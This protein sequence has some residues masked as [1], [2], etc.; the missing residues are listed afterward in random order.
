MTYTYD[1]LA[2]DNVMFLQG[3]QADLNKYLPKSQDAK[4]GTAIEGAFYLT[5]DTHRLYVGR[6][7]NDSNSQD[8][9]KIFPEEV[10]NGISVV[11][12]SGQLP[13]PA[14]V[15]AHDGDLYY[16]KNGNILAAYEEGEGWV[17]INSPTSISAIN[18]TFGSVQTAESGY[19][20]VDFV[21]SPTTSASNPVSLSIGAQTEGGSASDYIWFVPG[22]N[23]SL[24]RDSSDT[25]LRI[26]AI[27]NQELK[28]SATTYTTNSAPIILEEPT[29]NTTTQVNVVGEQDIHV[30]S[31]VSGSTN[32]ITVRGP[33]IQG[34]E[35]APLGTA[36]DS[37][38]VHGFTF[39]VVETS[40]AG[41][42]T[43]VNSNNNKTI[44]PVINYGDT[45]SPNTASS[46]YFHGGTARLDVY[47]ISQTEQAIQDAITESNK[48][49]DALHWKGTING[50]TALGALT[51]VAVG[52]VYK[53]AVDSNTTSTEAQ[54]GFTLPGGQVVKNGDTLIATLASGA[55]EDANGYIPSGSLVWAY[56]P[57]GDEPNV[58]GAVGTGTNP[59]FGVNDSN[60][61]APNDTILKVTIDNSSNE[62]ITATGSGSATNYTLTLAHDELDTAFNVASANLVSTTAGADSISSATNGSVTFLAINP[63]NGFT[64]DDYGH[65][66]SVSAQSITLKHNYLT[67]VSATHSASNTTSNGVTNYTGQ[68]AVGATDSIG[69]TITSG[70]VQLKSSTVKM[71]AAND[72]SY[73]TMDI[74]WGS[75]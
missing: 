59:L 25:A 10:S 27:G 65:L 36:N 30:K 73:L 18:A 29:N 26:D 9:N 69:S 51:N 23:I 68:V 48:S 74:V 28:T 57:S 3:T 70:N 41:A 12:T 5:T 72:N 19:N 47:T 38:S 37:T 61:S 71:T 22:D 14:S 66:E 50:S 8:N 75:F 64:V 43:T 13:N 55:S 58:V 31:E 2:G 4:R 63:S 40:T 67:A 1:V 54:N 16:V 7:V 53:F 33:G 6:K 49:L 17:Q 46:S 39:G 15:E 52:D 60:K 45:T 11:Q 34:V 35:A 20:S 24:T 32:T 21:T 44:D 42:A 62:K 56:V